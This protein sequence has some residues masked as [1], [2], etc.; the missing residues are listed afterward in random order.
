MPVS[1]RPDLGPADQHEAGVAVG[2]DRGDIQ[3]GP[4]VDPAAVAGIGRAAIPTTRAAHTW[5]ALAAGLVFL[6]V[7]L[8]FILQNVKSVPVHFFAAEWNIPL[9]VDLLLS[10]VLGALVTFM[11]GS[12]R[13]LQLRRVARRNAAGE[14][15]RRSV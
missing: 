5:V 11:T 4:G 7:I 1:R 6:V 2:R 9:A 12:L 15:G 14:P 8:V 13:I 10:A 3:D